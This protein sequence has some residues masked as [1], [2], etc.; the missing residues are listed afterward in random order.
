M[1]KLN[2]IIEMESQIKTMICNIVN[3]IESTVSQNSMDGVNQSSSGINCATVKFGSLD[4]GILCPYYYLQKE[5]ANIVRR[6]LD[7]AASATDLMETLKNMCEEKRVK[8]KDEFYRLNPKTLEILNTYL[9]AM[10]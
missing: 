2:K 6:K 1:E 4:T 8:W 5:Q 9:N 3:E 10:S 7:K